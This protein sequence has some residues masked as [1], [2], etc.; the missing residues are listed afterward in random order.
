VGAVAVGQGARLGGEA[1]QVGL[2][3]SIGTT[4]ILFCAAARTNASD[5]LG[6]AVT[7]NDRR[8]VPIPARFM[9]RS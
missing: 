2:S 5:A 4:R 8:I 9:A 6:G 3:S 7:S 1:A